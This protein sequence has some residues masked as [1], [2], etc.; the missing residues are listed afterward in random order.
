MNR[1]VF[2]AGYGGQGVLLAG[3]LLATAGMLEGKSVCYF[4][5]YGVEKR[6]GTA[7]CTVTLADMAIGSPIVGRPEAALLLN[8][9]VCDQY[10][11]RIR[12]RGFC[13]LNSSLVTP[14]VHC[15]D[16]EM[17]ALPLNEMAMQLGDIRLVNML[18]LGIYAQRTSTVILASLQAALSLVLPE[19]AHHLIPLN[20]SALEHGARS[21]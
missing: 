11:G 17:V 14:P 18:A 2:I 7:T 20:I 4:P 12:P 3:N 9:G 16:L 6:G 19:R 8:Q 1:N 5:A 15:E 21:C 13:L 10:L